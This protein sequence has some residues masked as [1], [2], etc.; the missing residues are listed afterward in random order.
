[1]TDDTHALL[2]ASKSNYQ[3]LLEGTTLPGVNYP[4]DLSQNLTSKR[5]SHKLAE[6]GRRNRINSALEEMRVL[7]PGS[8]TL[9]PL[10]GGAGGKDTMKSSSDSSTGE[11]TLATPTTA[12]KDAGASSANS[13]AATVEMA[14]EHIKSLNE[15]LASREG[16]NEALRR[17]LEGMKRRYPDLE[18]ESNEQ[19]GTSKA[20]APVA[21]GA[22]AKTV[23]K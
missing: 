4:S 14:I 15:R 12:A 6:Q 22:S 2:L 9:S 7:L 16:E 11:K 17:E 13:K 23:K 10:P 1:M 8:P 5:T 21:K 19:R 20:E 3:N 18:E